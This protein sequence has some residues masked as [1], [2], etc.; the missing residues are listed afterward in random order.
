MWGGFLKIM[1]FQVRGG[2]GTVC[3]PGTPSTERLVRLVR[4][5]LYPGAPGT[6][7][8]VRL[9]RLVRYG[10]YAWYCWHGT[11]GTAGTAGTVFFFCSRAALIMMI[12]A[13]FKADVHTR[14]PAVG[15]LGTGGKKQ[16]IRQNSK[17][18][19]TKQAQTT[20]TSSSQPTKRVRFF[21][22]ASCL[23]APKVLG[24]SPV[25]QHELSEIG[26]KLIEAKAK[27]KIT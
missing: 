7:Q 13:V 1:D 19:Q 17:N 16:R 23:G 21:F 5:S 26:R 12:V 9:E 11:L 4:Y 2:G 10:W 15:G 18:Q 24:G 20:V 3:T 25:S 8:F 27:V 14:N 22:A 6:V